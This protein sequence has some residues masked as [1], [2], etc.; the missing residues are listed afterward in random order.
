[1]KELAKKLATKGVD[2]VLKQMTGDDIIFENEI[3]SQR[4]NI[5]GTGGSQGKQWLKSMF[6][7]FNLRYQELIRRET[8]AQYD[9]EGKIKPIST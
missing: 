8:M 2:D 6:D 3:I 5:A 4:D 9:D 1:M 7:K